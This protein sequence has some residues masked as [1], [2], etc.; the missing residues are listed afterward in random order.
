MARLLDGRRD[1][2][3]FRLGKGSDAAAEIDGNKKDSVRDTQ[4]M[5]VRHAS[6]LPPAPPPESPLLLPRD[7]PPF[8]YRGER[9]D[10]ETTVASKSRPGAFEGL[11]SEDIT[12]FYRLFRELCKRFML[13]YDYGLNED[14]AKALL[15]HHGLPTDLID[16]TWQGG[17]AMAFAAAHGTEVGRICIMPIGQDA[18]APQLADLSRHPWAHR[19]QM[20]KAVGVIMP[21]GYD[22]LKSRGN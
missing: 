1:P 15:Q 19:A 14:L 17:L 11:S 7:G 21:E 5:D 22:D 10:F 3:V 9:G 2:Y 20:Q 4:P 12:A 8:I 6:M 18:R 16:F 13:N